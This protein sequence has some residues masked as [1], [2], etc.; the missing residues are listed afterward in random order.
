MLKKIQAEL[1]ETQIATVRSM[2][3]LDPAVLLGN[4]AQ[5]DDPNVSQASSEVNP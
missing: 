4:Y 5:V 3:G 2:Y 1:E